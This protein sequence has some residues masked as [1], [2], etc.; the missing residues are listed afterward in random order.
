M[1]ELIGKMGD[2]WSISLKAYFSDDEIKPAQQIINKA[3]AASG[4]PPDSILR[5]RNLAGIV[6]E[7]G[8]LNKSL[9][10]EGDVIVGSSKEWADEL[11]SYYRDFGVDSFIFWPSIEGEELEQVRLFGESVM[12]TVRESMK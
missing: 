5:I 7:E 12:P 4:R 11:V 1:L 3:A 10:G 6:D 8:N 9:H 2:G